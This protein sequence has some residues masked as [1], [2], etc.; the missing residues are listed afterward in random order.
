MKTPVLAPEIA[1]SWHHV[2]LST[3]VEIGSP[4]RELNY[5]LIINT[6]NNGTRHQY[7]FVEHLWLLFFSLSYVEASPRSHFCLRAISFENG[8]ISEKLPQFGSQ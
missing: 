5:P 7:S 6:H 1:S 8:Q 2:P 3:L 4:G